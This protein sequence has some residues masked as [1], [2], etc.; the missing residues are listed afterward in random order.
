MNFI[1]ED[2]GA[3]PK[4]FDVAEKKEE[5]RIIAE[6]RQRTPRAPKGRD[7][8]QPKE[9]ESGKSSILGSVSGRSARFV[10]KSSTKI[11]ARLSVLLP[12]MRRDLR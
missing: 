5:D 1:V 8:E 2:C 12:F 9:A 3:L 6:L 4:S 7:A 11:N 10:A